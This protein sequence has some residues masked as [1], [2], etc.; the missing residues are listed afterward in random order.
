MIQE[1]ITPCW[2]PGYIERSRRKLHKFWTVGSR[3]VL[4]VWRQ[5]SL[6]NEREWS[7]RFFARLWR[8]MAD[9]V[10][11]WV[12][13]TGP[14]GEWLGNTHRG[15]GLETICLGRSLKEGDGGVA[16][17]DATCATHEGYLSRQ[18]VHFSQA[19]VDQ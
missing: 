19:T 4:G 16:A 5:L 15:S 9:G 17:H 6:G 18:V 8:L 13:A 7:A 14:C 1:T 11:G 10:E 2:E 3:V 12:K